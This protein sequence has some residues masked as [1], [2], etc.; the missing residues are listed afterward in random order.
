MSTDKRIRAAMANCTKGEAT[1]MVLPA[2]IRALDLDTLADVVGWRDAKAPDK[3]VLLV[4]GDEEPV[5]IALR[6]AAN[7]VGATAMCALCRTTHGPGGTSLFSAPRGRGGD[8]VGTYVCS[9]LG[10]ARHITVQKA[11]AALRPAPG[12]SVEERRAG[13]RERAAAFAAQVTAPR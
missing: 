2:E 5:G 8:S 11:T 10:C 7:P 9:D 1:R 6:A 3:A 12:L 4:P 13:L